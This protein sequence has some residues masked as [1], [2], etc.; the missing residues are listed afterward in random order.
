MQEYDD[1]LKMMQNS[2]KSENKKKG[3]IIASSSVMFFPLMQCTH[4]AV[5]SA[6]CCQNSIKRNETKETKT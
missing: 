5:A 6:Q 4:N 2:L 3:S 1:D